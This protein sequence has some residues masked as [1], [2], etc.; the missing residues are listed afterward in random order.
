MYGDP[1]P[2]CRIYIPL[3]C[4]YGDLGLNC[5]SLIPTNIS[6]HTVSYPILATSY[7]FTALTQSLEKPKPKC[8]KLA[9]ISEACC[10]HNNRFKPQIL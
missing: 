5:Q 2:N 9:S 4:Y 3:M 1:V 7:E 10:N 8:N 6:G